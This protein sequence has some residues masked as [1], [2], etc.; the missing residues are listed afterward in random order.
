[1]R[2]RVRSD[3]SSLELLLDTI[4]NTFGGVLFLAI[5]VA[6]MLRT[7][8]PAGRRAGDESTAP[9]SAEERASLKIKVAA[10]RDDLV[11]AQEELQAARTNGRGAESPA[12]DESQSLID[13]I[14]R[15][16]DERANAVTETADYQERA[17]SAEEQTRLEAESLARIRE[18]LRDAEKARD[19]AAEAAA[20]LT[21]SRLDLE[22]AEQRPTIDVVA[23]FPTLRGTEKRQV[24]LYLRFGRLYMMHAWRNGER[25][26]PNT[27]HFFVA[28]GEP[29]VAVPRP[30]A[31]V[32]VTDA[33]IRDSVR[34]MLA[35]F[36]P[37][38]WAVAAVLFGD[39]HEHFQ[40]LRKALVESGYEYNPIPVR[41]GGSV[42]DTGGTSQAQ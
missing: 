3:D 9:M 6:L 23:G 13:A 1:V 37:R 16:V 30:G 20:A 41:P 39:S 32:V 11:S 19:E 15:A 17:A 35:D 24:G 21:R 2:R 4:T 29:P 18:R 27:E 10:A 14:A 42:F 31:G 28:P 36:P 33:T 25:L 7:S 5:L 34:R 38:D 22:T 8:A 40:L 12:V 26:G